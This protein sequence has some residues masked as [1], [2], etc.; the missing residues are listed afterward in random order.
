MYYK[1]TDNGYVL[2]LKVSPNASRFGAFGIFTDPE[3]QDFLKIA[4]NAVPEKGKAN[5]AV[6]KLL[7][8]LL[9][10]NKKSFSVLSGETGH[11]KTILLTAPHAEQIEKA[12]NQLG[13]AS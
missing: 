8:K 11:Y 5:I 13:E 6:I 4:V 7:S 2:R 1:K 3:G 10:Q 12:L 9:S